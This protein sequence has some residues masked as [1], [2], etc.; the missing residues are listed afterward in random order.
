MS[1][2]ER[3]EVVATQIRAAGVVAQVA[4]LSDIRLESL[5]CSA[6]VDK[7]EIV[8]QDCDLRIATGTKYD[9]DEDSASLIVRVRAR[10]ELHELHGAGDKAGRPVVQIKA[11]FRLTYQLPE[12]PPPE[13]MKEELFS[14]FAAV[15]GVYN[16]WPYLR[17][18]VQSTTARMG[19][20]G[21]LIPL[22][23]IPKVGDA[24]TQTEVPPTRLKLVAGE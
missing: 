20:P 4:D 21:I 15:N 1:A 6:P 8:G 7:D 9:H 13:E 19:Y 14:S 16:A 24:P 3:D 5:G 17:E 10:V 23:R 12:N 22:Y 2:R 18:L 11:I